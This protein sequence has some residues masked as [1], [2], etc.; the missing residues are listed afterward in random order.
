L[1]Y[2]HI[3][4]NEETWNNAKIHSDISKKLVELVFDEL[5]LIG[6]AFM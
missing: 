3:K 6:T 2:L 5:T 4:S 1:H